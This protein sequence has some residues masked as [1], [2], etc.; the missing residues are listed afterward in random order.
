MFDLVHARTLLLNV[1]N[2]AEIVAEMLRIT[3]PGGVVASEEPDAAAWSCDPPHPTFDILRSAVLNAYRRT[4]KDFNIGRRI[5]RILRNAGL[6]DVQVRAIARLSS[7][8]FFRDRRDA[9]I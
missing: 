1:T 2:P 8:V 4:G 6:D 5:A 7:I 3:R 9:E